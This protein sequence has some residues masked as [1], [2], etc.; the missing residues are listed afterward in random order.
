MAPKGVTVNGIAPV[1]INT[2]MMAQRPKSYLDAAIA[3]VPMGRMSETDDYL[4]IAL[5][6]ASE[7]GKYV[8][9]QTLLIDGGWSCTRVFTYDKD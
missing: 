3:Q 2:P 4:G 1:W 7:A 9:G 6:L 8:T 5:Y